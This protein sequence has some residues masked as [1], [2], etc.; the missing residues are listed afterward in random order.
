M[1]LNIR[2]ILVEPLY[3]G[4]VGSVAR[5]MKN[6]GFTDLAI[7][8]PCKIGGNA[9]AMASH[10]KDVLKNASTYTSLKDAI[11]DDVNIVIGTTG[12]TGSK[13]NEHIRLPA[14]TPRQLKEKMNGVNAKIA[15]LFGREDNGFTND[16]LKMCDIIL[17]IPT[18]NDYPVMNLSHAVGVVLYEMSSI[19][20]GD[21]PIAER[22]DQELLI[23]HIR[24]VLDNIDY[25]EHKLDKTLLMIRRI[26]GRAKLTPREVQTLRGILRTIQYKL[27]LL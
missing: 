27:G 25:P 16:E 21:Y 1:S 10:A 5:A 18:S 17:S 3:E 11:E 20:A 7:V 19:E 24:N 6:F 13:Y 8:N 22:F 26:C 15:I 9:R 14:F 4:N 2:V 12:I 23:D